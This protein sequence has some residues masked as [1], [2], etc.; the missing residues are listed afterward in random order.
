MH[1]RARQLGWPYFT[2]GTGEYFFFG[3][4]NLDLVP[5]IYKGR[6]KLWEGS[7]DPVKALRSKGEAIM[8]FQYFN[9][10]VLRYLTISN[11]NENPLEKSPPNAA[12]ETRYFAVIGVRFINYFF[13][14]LKKK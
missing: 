10:E 12:A 13:K 11:V 2:Q 9:A 6:L 8:H 5:R 4:P 7:L 1:Y 14:Q 3:L